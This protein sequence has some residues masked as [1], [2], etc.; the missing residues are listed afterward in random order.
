MINEKAVGRWGDIWERSVTVPI[1]IGT[2]L[3]MCS[4]LLMK[5]FL[6]FSSKGKDDKDAKKSAKKKVKKTDLPVEQLVPQLPQEEIHKLI[7]R[8]VSYLIIH[9]FSLVL[10]LRHFSLR[11]YC[12][13]CS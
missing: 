8:E 3:F 5:K 9:F 11:N 7:E 6:H 1:T 10:F 4:D 2:S 12:G 13:F